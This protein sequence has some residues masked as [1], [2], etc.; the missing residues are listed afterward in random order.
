MIATPTGAFSTGVDAIVPGSQR[1]LLD[2][3]RMIPSRA[4]DE[5]LAEL[6]WE[7]NRIQTVYPGT[8]LRLVYELLPTT[9]PEEPSRTAKTR[10][11]TI[12]RTGSLCLEASSSGD[13]LLLSSA[14]GIPDAATCGMVS[15]P[16]RNPKRIGNDC[17]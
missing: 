17:V 12:T 16:A 6:L 7:L 10:H 13:K 4:H 11:S 15:Q 3:V 2:G 9:A 8:S 5:A 1:G 14:T